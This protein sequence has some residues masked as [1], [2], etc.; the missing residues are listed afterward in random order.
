MCLLETKIQ[1]MVVGAVHNLGV[2]RC[3]EWVVVNAKDAVGGVLVFWDNMVLQLVG[4]EVG[5]FSIS[6]WFKN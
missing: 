5:N 4:M 3:L 1:E 2:D 6:C